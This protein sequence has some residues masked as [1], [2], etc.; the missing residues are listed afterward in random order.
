MPFETLMLA[1]APVFSASVRSVD[2]ARRWFRARQLGG[3]QKAYA[4]QIDNTQPGE[5]TQP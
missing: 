5:S 4:R 2:K 3:M 1:N